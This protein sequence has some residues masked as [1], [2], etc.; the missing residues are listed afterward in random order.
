MRA[1]PLE[2]MTIET[3]CPYL[4]AEPWRGKRNHPALVGFTAASIAGIKKLPIEDVWAATGRT[5]TAFFNLE[6]I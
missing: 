6:D 1:I 5:A 3:D 4:S 2:R